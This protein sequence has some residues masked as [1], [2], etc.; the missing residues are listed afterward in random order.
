MGYLI[1]E[2]K[3]KTFYIIDIILLTVLILLVLYAFI[4][5]NFIH[6]V[7]TVKIVCNGYTFNG[8]EFNFMT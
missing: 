5:G 8:S 6:N 1:Q 7:E 4:D 2:N 3:T